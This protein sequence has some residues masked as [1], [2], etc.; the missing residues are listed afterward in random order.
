MEKSD[1]TF[2]QGCTVRVKK[3]RF[4]KHAY[5]HKRYPIM[6]QNRIMIYSRPVLH[7]EFQSFIVNIIYLT[8]FAG[9]KVP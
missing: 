9:K 8:I 2:A 7:Q 1:V 4:V 6:S 5:K 3:K